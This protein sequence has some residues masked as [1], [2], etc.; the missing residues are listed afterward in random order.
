MHFDLQHNSPKKGDRLIASCG[1]SR[2]QLTPHTAE[3]R[4]LACKTN[5]AFAKIPPDYQTNLSHYVDIA[6]ED[7]ELIQFVKLYDDTLPTEPLPALTGTAMV[8]PDPTAGEQS[9]RKRTFAN[10]PQSKTGNY[11][12]ARYGF[13]DPVDEATYNDANYLV[14]PA[15]TAVSILKMYVDYATQNAATSRTL[16]AYINMDTPGLSEMATFI[17]SLGKNKVAEIKPEFDKD[18]NA[19]TFKTDCFGHKAG[20]IVYR[21]ALNEEV[22][23]YGRQPLKYILQKIADDDSYKGRM[24]DVRQ[25]QTARFA[26]SSPQ[27]PQQRRFVATLTVGKGDGGYTF[28]PDNLSPGHGISFDQGTISFSG[29]KFSIGVHNDFLRTISAFVEFYD[30]AG[31]V[32]KQIIDP[33]AWWET[34]DK[35]YLKMVLA[36]STIM[37]IPLPSDPQTLSFD[38]PESARRAKIILGSLGT[39]AWDATA[40]WQGAFNTAVFQYAIPMMFL[41]AGAKVE[42]SKWMDKFLGENDSIL[43]AIAAAIPIVGGSWAANN[44]LG[45]TTSL[46]VLVA[47]SLVSILTEAAWVY[48]ATHIA[49]KITEAEV[50]DSI[51]FV[52]WAIRAVNTAVDW[53]CIGETT[54]QCL[55]SPAATSLNIKRSFDMQVTVKP[56]PTHTIWPETAVRWQ[57][58]VQYKCDDSDASPYVSKDTL[59]SVSSSEPVVYTF[60]N[61][62]AGGQLKIFFACFSDRDWIAGQWESDFIDALLPSGQSVLKVGGEI[63]ENLVPLDSTSQY[64]F[65]EKL[66]YDASNGGHI[67]KDGPIPTALVGSLDTGNIGHLIGSINGIVINQVYQ[68]G[69]AWQASEQDIPISG[70]S[71]VYTGQQFTLQNI[72]GLDKPESTLKFVEHGYGSMVHLAYN[73]YEDNDAYAILPLPLKPGEPVS[74]NIHRVNLSTAGGILDIDFDHTYGMFQA[75]NNIE[76]VCVHPQGYLVGIQRENHKLLIFKLPANPFPLTEEYVPVS[77]MLGGKGV[78]QGLFFDPVAVSIAAGGEILVL[79]A[80]NQRVQALTAAGYPV[81]KFRGDQRF[82]VTSPSASIIVDIESGRVSEEI[83]QTFVSNNILLTQ[84]WSII[85][86]EAGNFTIKGDEASLSGPYKVFQLAEEMFTLDMSVDWLP[87][88]CSQT[89]TDAL[90]A[91]FSAQDPP[92]SISSSAALT[93]SVTMFN[94][95]GEDNDEF[96]ITDSLAS[97]S[98]QL[99]HPEDGALTVFDYVPFFYLERHDVTEITFMDL[100]V[101]IKGFIYILYYV[102]DGSTLD[103]YRLDLYDPLGTFLSTTP[104]TDLEATAKGIPAGKITVDIWRNMLALNFEAILGPNDRTEPQVSKYIPTTPYGL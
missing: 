60:K 79:E 71:E 41:I 16:D 29:S 34:E 83:R 25:N 36:V 97:V 53:A 70:Q 3:S 54:L 103:Q 37:A 56:D 66:I 52:G 80:Q 44:A 58:T 28:T 22:W 8:L 33:D 50:I 23:E 94:I 11:Q 5:R 47:D 27:H 82:A 13:T 15:S 91:Q 77:N 72:S 104:N 99:M 74:Y 73:Q 89:V 26:Q 17:S 78:R 88:L 46:F 14:T 100:A 49:L 19:L 1:K 90:K 61:I 43:K 48:I 32:V 63:T 75:V 93:D 55:T 68:V 31:N 18:G 59:S 51:P 24:W 101:E 96:V 9:A 67:W 45:N 20:E 57:M 102:E 86:S 76:C 87:D 42:N 39:S 98:Y 40:S 35:R 38:W 84:S 6:F 4:A 62:P 65:K 92:I 10:S 64:I 95:S 81:P 7:E 12:L 21:Y 2:V 69:Y 85:D 30:E